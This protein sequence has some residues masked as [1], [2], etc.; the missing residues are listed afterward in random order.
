MNIVNRF[1][2]QVALL[3][4]PL[5][6]RM[7]VDMSQLKIILETKL[8]MDDRRP[9]TLHQARS[10]R[11]EKA[12]NLATI[13]TMVM[14]AL[15][16]LFYLFAF[17]LGTDKITQL[18]F[19][20]SMFFFMLSATLIS[21][22][23]S[24]LID[25]RDT[26]IILPKPVTDR[27]FVMAR[28]LHIF[29][30]ICKIVLPMCIPGFIYMVYQTGWAGALLFLLL[31][32]FVTLFSIFFVNAVYLLILRLTTPQR[33]Q[34]IISSIQIFFAILIY[35]SY[36][37]F[38]RL[39]SQHRLENFDLSTKTGIELYP[40]YW[41][42]C[43]WKVVYSF[44]GTT[45]QTI[46]AIAGLV[47]PFLS[48]FIVIKYLAPSFNNKLALINNSSS[49]A[50]SPQKQKKTRR[51]TYAEFL[52]ALVTRSRVERMGFLFTWKM[53]S[54][55][56]DFKMKVYPGIGYLVVIVAVSVMNS[57]KSDLDSISQNSGA[58][59]ALVIY[60]L[61]FSSLLLVMAIGQINFSDRFKASWIYYVA[62]LSKPGEV[63][64]GAAKAAILKF[65]IPLVALITVAGIWIAGFSIL[66]NIIL[67]LFN[68]LLIATMLVYVGHKMFPFSMHQATSSKSGS[69]LRNLAVFFI[70]GLI[71]VGHYMIYNFTIAVMICAI[72][73]ITATI[74]LMSS[75]KNTSWAAIRS[76]YDEA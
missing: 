37:F 52:A 73:S 43:T 14:S 57:W 4:E 8:L 60:G 35:A 22:F 25:I 6:R 29:I 44:S 48:L 72:L 28:L 63:I 36:Q 46:A 75:I 31:I 3:P 51:K 41:M 68:E 56:R 38:P 64:S 55:S 17:S 39:I 15:L 18:C 59:R 7:G 58:G 40:L 13:G 50:A 71:G 53:S 66:P 19:Y 33:F 30:H 12:I 11:K 74:V 54:R 27:T 16:G 5:F 9:T 1:L 62:P 70:S 69:F 45:Q 65:Y 2:L 21:D 10:N 61:Y 67:G 24:V 20:F 49:Q 47:L 34:S 23:T 32:W 26:F 42:A 76:S